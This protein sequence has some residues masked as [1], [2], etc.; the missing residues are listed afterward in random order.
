MQANSE[1]R[2]RAKDRGVKLW[3][4]GQALG[5]SEATVTRWLRVELSG[6]KRAAMLQAIDQIAAQR[7]E[8]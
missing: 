4:I 3:E 5:V 7:K 6:K 2:K 8:V 1:V